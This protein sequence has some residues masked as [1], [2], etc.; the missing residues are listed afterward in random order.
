[1]YKAIRGGCDT[2]AVKIMK[3]HQDARSA[4]L[5]AREACPPSQV[6]HES[7]GLQLVALQRHKVPALHLG[8]DAAS[9]GLPPADLHPAL[10]PSCADIQIYGR[11]HSAEWAGCLQI[12]ILASARHPNILVRPA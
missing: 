5:F 8:A 3:G 7:T 10:L 9:L 4:D 2:V 12:E 1:M 11:L 6:T